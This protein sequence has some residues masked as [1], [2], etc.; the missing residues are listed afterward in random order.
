M[1]IT[2]T[3]PRGESCDFVESWFT[4]ES[5]IGEFPVP[6]KPSD[7]VPGDYLYVIYRKRIVGRFVVDHI[8]RIEVGD[9]PIIGS[10]AVMA[11]GKYNVVVNRPGEK[12]PVEIHRRGHVGIRYDTVPEWR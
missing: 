8:E 6:G 11:T 9:E 10:D 7:V 3:I 12:A 2:R 4:G 5:R 1:D